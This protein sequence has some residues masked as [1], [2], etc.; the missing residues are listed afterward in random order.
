[1]TPSAD[2]SPI[3]RLVA[4]A[5]DEGLTARETRTGTTGAKR[6]FAFDRPM[7]RAVR[8][9][10][11]CD[12][13][14]ATIF[15]ALGTD[16][17]LREGFEHRA[18]WE[19]AHFPVPFWSLARLKFRLRQARV[20]RNTAAMHR[21]ELQLQTVLS[22]TGAAPAL[23]D[24]G[25]V[26]PDTHEYERMSAARAV[27]WQRAQQD[28]ASDGLGVPWCYGDSHNWMFVISVSTEQEWRAALGGDRLAA[29]AGRLVRTLMR[30]VLLADDFTLRLEI[31]SDE[32]VNAAEGWQF[33]LRGDS[34][35]EAVSIW[36]MHGGSVER[37][38]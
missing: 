37:C 24:R 12:P 4:L 25:K 14:L 35:P 2:V 19:Q 36:R 13:E 26:G 1:M 28:L 17:S 7:T 18:T 32:R 10:G 8:R 15:W 22:R 11:R 16:D 38:G 27:V 31:D 34:R 33:R 20:R 30:T 3:E 6:I 23:L 5:A 29:L 21:R 9:A